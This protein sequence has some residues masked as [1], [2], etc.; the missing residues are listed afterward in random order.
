MYDVN[1]LAALASVIRFGSFDAAA[2]ALNVTPSAISQRIRALEEHV[3]TPLVRRSA[4]CVATPI[5]ARLAR[6]FDDLRLLQTA[7]DADLGQPTQPA[8]VR[9]ALNADSLATWALPALA[10]V[11]AHLFDITIDDQDHSAD[12]LKRGEV[13][14]AITSDPGPVLGCDSTPLGLLRYRATASPGF[15]QQHFA[16]GLTVTA[17][18]SAPSLCFNAKDSLQSRW[19]RLVTGDALVLPH[20]TVGSSTAFVQAA[21]LGMGW[22]MNPEQLI[23]PLIASGDLVDLAPD[24]PLDVPLYWQVSRLLGKPLAPLTVAIVT[25]ARATLLP[26]HLS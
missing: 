21:Q 22:G 23:A 25:M 6:H 14:A 1:Q 2:Q 19:A 15:V 3:G 7:L 8:P 11:P 13:A 10:Q 12:W 18:R 17:L 16:Q 20:H 5:G 24:A 9:L 26:F 4:P